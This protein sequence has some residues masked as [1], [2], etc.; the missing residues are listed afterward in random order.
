MHA[1]RRISTTRLKTV[2]SIAI[3]PG[4]GAG[5]SEARLGRWRAAMAG[6][7]ARGAVPGLVAFLSR[8][9]ETHVETV[10]AQAVGGAPM[11]RDTIFRI[12]SMTK[13]VT[14]AAAMMLVEEGKLRLDEP[15]ERWL[16]E[17]ANRR[18]LSRLD[19]PLQDTMLAK[20]V[21]TLRDLLTFRLGFGQIMA[22]PDQYPIAKAALELQIGM[23]PPEPGR[24]PPPDEWLRRLG[25][26][27]LMHQP[28]EAWMY[29]TG[30]DLLGVL[31]ARATGQRFETVL[32]ERLFDPLG[33]SDTAF[34][35]PPTKQPRFAAAYWTSFSDGSLALHDD[36][37]TGQWSSP[38]PLP[39]GGAGL[40]S[41]VDDYAKFAQMLLN[42]GRLGE[43]RLLSRPAVA[44]MTGDQLTPAQKEAAHFIPGFFDDQG[45]GFGMAVQ[46]R[47][48]GLG[49]VGRYGWAGGFG[50]S[51]ANDPAEGLIGILMTQASFT[52]PT[53]PAVHQD[54]WTMAYAAIDD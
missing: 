8:R 23:G 45:W 14:A 5:F 26:L 46:T 29:N 36:P 43:I 41:T 39:L 4:M 49:T 6:H 22:P 28:G 12:T 2:A 33:M 37:G 51:W 21:I 54:F 19:A 34:F 24:M 18:V 50:T 1:P 35:V 11:R 3:E 16:P 7:V 27:P 38:P 13:P 48:T 10:G 40:V 31:I 30:A 17:L 47:R 44:L 20:R 53:P 42:H 25:T 32:H 9:G 15:V 52:S